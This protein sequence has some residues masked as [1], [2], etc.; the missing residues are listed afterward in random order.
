MSISNIFG[1]LTFNKDVMKSRLSKKACRK[2]LS[3][4]QAGDFLDESIAGDVAHAMKTWAIENNATHFT[5]WFQPQRGGTAEKHDSFLDYDDDGEII[6]RFSASQLIQSEPDASSFPSGGIRSTFE[7]RGYTAWDPTSPAFLLEVRGTRTLVIPSVF[8]SWTGAVLDIKTPFLRSGRALSDAIIK[9]QKILGRNVR[10]IKV[11]AGLEQEYFLFNRQLFETRPD[12]QVCN[13]TLFG[14]EPARGQQLADHYF[15]SIKDKVINFMNNLDVELYRRGIPSKTRHNEVA[16]NQFEIAPLHEEAN[17]AIDHNLQMMDL[18][19]RVAEKHDLVA[20]MHEK[21]MA[22]VNGSGKHYNFSI[23]DEFGTNYLA[24]ST[25]TEGNLLF[26]LSLCALFTGIHKYGAVLRASVA[27]AGNDHRLGANEA[28]PAIM[29]VYVGEML[30]QILDEIEDIGSVPG[31]NL[32]H[33]SSGVANLPNVTR[34]YSDRNRT[35]PLA[36]TGN[37]FEFRA[38]GSSHNSGEAATALNLLLAYGY[39]EIATR[40]EDIRSTLPIVE[41]AWLVIEQIVKET[42]DIRF[43]GNG[44][45][46]EWREE[47]ARRGLPDT[48]N[49][50]ESLECLYD[51]EVIDLFESFH[52]LSE[53]ELRSKVEIKLDAYIKSREIEFKTALDM[54]RTMILPAVSRQLAMLSQAHAAVKAGGVKKSPVSEDIIRMTGIYSDI[55][56]GIDALELALSN[57]RKETPLL[58]RAKSYAAGCSEAMEQLRF[59]A[60][61]AEQHVAH[62]L[63]PMAKYQQLLTIL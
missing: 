30:K 36:F 27:D 51:P 56:A 47:A 37:K 44:Y 4:I 38:P 32:S 43:E 31:K 50:P 54:A 10:H 62:E 24:P 15:G 60:D 19:R 61:K 55:K 17:L 29:S 26:L 41:K 52:V 7:A 18:M 20:I 33:I 58:R 35:S 39:T 57:A 12:L 59:A 48:A 40:I 11:L 46:Q 6:E 5:H 16:P 21:P 9:L 53:Q 42:R 13:R 3:T 25:D 63:W 49:T 14:A 2:L 23:R 8:L 22:R 1:E 45:A 28:P 34:D